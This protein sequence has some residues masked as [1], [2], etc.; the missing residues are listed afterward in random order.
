MGR[1]KEYI[2][3]ELLEK[4][5][6]LFRKN[7]YHATGTDELASEFGINKK[8]L[9]AE[10]GSKLN[11]FQSCLEHYES[12]FLNLIL[13]PVENQNANL[14]R[15]KEVFQA[16]V[17]YGEK[18]LRGLG[19]LICN[20]SSDRGSLDPCIGPIVDRYFERIENGFYKA[21][22]NSKTSSKKIKSDN[23][24]QISS[25]LTTTLVGIATSIRAEAP[26]SQIRK[27]YKFIEEYLKSLQ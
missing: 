11:L 19:C 4:S 9:Y 7:G 24:K 15:I 20:T 26:V 25:F 18:D 16:I 8:S 21:L 27:T 23:V 13:S 6:Q 17:R 10:F 5:I 14:E 22:L 3:E 12:T 2:R 1:K